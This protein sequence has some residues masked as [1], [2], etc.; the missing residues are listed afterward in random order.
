MGNKRTPSLDQWAPV[1]KPNCSAC[2]DTA[3]MARDGPC[4]LRPPSSGYPWH[5]GKLTVHQR[6][7]VEP[8]MAQMPRVTTTPLP[9]WVVI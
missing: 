6:S 2:A 5:L 7:G 9:H 4:L 3:N 1:A 8:E